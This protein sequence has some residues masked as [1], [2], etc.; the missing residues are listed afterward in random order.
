MNKRYL[1]TVV[2]SVILCVQL[3][4]INRRETDAAD[5]TGEITEAITTD[6]RMQGVWV[7]TTLNLDYPS[8]GT[9]DSVTLKS[10]ADTIIENCADMG[11]TDIFLQVRPEADAFYKSEIYPWSQRLTGSQGIAPDND[12]DPLEYWV[13]ECHK[14]GMKLHAWI[15]PYRVTNTTGVKAE[16]LALTSPARQNT[17]WV[18]EF[19]GKLY[20][21]PAIP[22][23]RELVISGVEEIV[24]NYEVDGIHLD[25]YFYP[26]AGF[27]DSDS[28]AKYG[29]GKN[30]DDWRRENVDALV[31]GI[32]NKIEEIDGS[33]E[34]GISPVGVWANKK[35]NPLGSDTYGSESYYKNYADTRK[36]AL[37]E[38]VDYIAPQIYWEIG[39]KTI[40]YKT[41]V[42]WWAET[43][44]N[45]NTKLYVG[46]ADYKCDGAA[47]SSAWYNGG[48]IQE[49]IDLNKSISKVSG[50]IHFRYKFIN[51]LEYLKNIVKSVNNSSIQ[52][53][54]AVTENTSEVTTES[55]VTTEEAGKIVN[56]TDDI[57]VVLD[58]KIL[59]FDQKPV[60]K[61]SRT[62]VPFRKILEEL[63]AD[64]SW[65]NDTQQVKA[66]K[67]DI[68]ISF[69]IGE[70]VL[71]VNQKDTIIMDTEPQII[72]SRSMVPLRVISET[73]G[74]E[75]DWDNDQR[76]ITIKSTE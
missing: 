37:K 28:Y 39:N 57:M 68:E 29:N 65:N 64:V 7:S 11:I 32:H 69:V 24:K 27:D 16:S 18:K 10:E 30:K 20:F 75:V 59:E 21:D 40:D 42:E 44:K 47:S 54:G 35:N 56:N 66:V 25:D 76:I 3:M 63:G 36:W 72:N 74:A 49:Q 71:L 5:S 38:W 55:V 51:N 12:F 26:G 4:G 15:N 31:E 58:G 43:L 53:S 2:L 48:A 41:A 70:K 22:E 67:D 45:C 62:L 50:E 6:K 61:N 34:F 60:I 46:L 14:K 23:V 52:A 8:K 73:L 1:I 17:Q 19:E 13:D 9:T 33:V